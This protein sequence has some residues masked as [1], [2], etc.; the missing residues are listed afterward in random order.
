MLTISAL[1][2]TIG[3]SPLF[4]AEAVAIRV[5]LLIAVRVTV[6]LLSLHTMRR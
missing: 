4:L 2:L 5:L 3:Y 1:W 6:H